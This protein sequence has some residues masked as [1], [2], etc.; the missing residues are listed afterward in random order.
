M[1]NASD[2][3]APITAVILAGSP[4]ASCNAS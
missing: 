2:P 4:P 3:P 1:L